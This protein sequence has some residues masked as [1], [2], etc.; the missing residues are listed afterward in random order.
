MLKN[1]RLIV[2]LNHYY[3]VLRQAWKTRHFEHRELYEKYE[4]EFL[5]D[6]M[7]LQETCSS[8]YL[9]WITY[10]LAAI[11]ILLLVW[12]F[13][14]RVDIVAVASGRLASE[15]YTKVIQPLT[16]GMVKRILVQN[17]DQVKAGQLLIELDATESQASIIKLESL[18]PIL[19]SKVNSYK[20]LLKDGYIAQHDVFD[21][22]RELLEVSTQ[23]AQAK[24]I[25]ST[26]QIKSPVDGTVS[27]LNIYTVGGVVSPG[28]TLMS[29]VPSGSAITLDAYLN[30]KDIG[31]IKVGQDV[32]VKLEAFPFTRY[33]HLDGKVILI[34]QDSI[35]RPGEKPAKIKEANLEKTNQ[36]AN[37]YLVSVELSSGDI[38]VDGRKVPLLP[39]MVATAEIKTGTRKLISYILSPLVENVSEA[40]RER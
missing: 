31:F 14:G 24:F 36:V 26:M 1:N 34:A 30:N 16:A 7:E 29:I 15:G 5:P 13:F 20:A 27:G 4:S 12:A 8:P 35:E 21:K 32:A 40:A 11:L 3:E 39:G 19:Q 25:N 18:T 22:E 9:R 23:L 17:G 33:G 28:Q 2:L 38:E 37:N 6:A 10:S